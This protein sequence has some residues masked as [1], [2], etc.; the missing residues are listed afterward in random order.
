MIDPFLDYS[1]ATFRLYYERIAT[2]TITGSGNIAPIAVANGD[3]SAFT[4][5]AIN[6]I[7]MGSKDTDG[8][9]VSYHWTFGDNSESLDTNPIYS[10]ATAGNY[11]VSLTVTDNDGASHTDTV[12]VVVNAQSSNLVDACASQALITG[13]I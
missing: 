6:F 10:Y 13:L 11:V 2:V 9:I 5:E 12:M 4:G 1:G 3:Y 8:T 7:N